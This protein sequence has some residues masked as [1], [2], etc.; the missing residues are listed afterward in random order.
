[1][2]LF[3]SNCSKIDSNVLWCYLLLV[4]V[5]CNCS[6]NSCDNT[7]GATTCNNPCCNTAGATTCNCG[8]SNGNS[9]LPMLLLLLCCCGTGKGSTC[10]C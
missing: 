4:C 7:A 10:A 8:T 2:N 9:F 1:M 3:G 5:L 6:N